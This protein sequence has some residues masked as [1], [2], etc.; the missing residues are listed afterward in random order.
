M[1]LIVHE[2]ADPSKHEGDVQGEPA[3][4]VICFGRGRYALIFP[5]GAV[6]GYQPAYTL[7]NTCAGDE[8]VI[9]RLE[10]NSDRVLAWEKAHIYGAA[11]ISENSPRIIWPDARV[12][13]A[14]EDGGG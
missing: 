13:K 10:E 3:T 2:I 4:C 12:H 14:L 5:D 11:L 7:C 6:S 1:K 8:A 9:K